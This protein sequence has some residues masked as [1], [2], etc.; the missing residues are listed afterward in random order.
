AA[1]G[2]MAVAGRD[3]GDDHSEDHGLDQG[4]G[5]DVGIEIVLNAGDVVGGA[6]DAGER[7]GEP[8]AE[9]AQEHADDDQERVDQRRG[10]DLRQDKVTGGIHPHDVQRIDLFPNAHGA[11]LRRYRGPHFARQDQGDDGGAELEYGALPY[12]EAH[13]VLGDQGRVNVRFGL[14]GDHRAHEERKQRNDA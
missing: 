6:D 10:D 2:V 4:I 5:D 12:R 9:D 7:A 13:H 14:D 8:S 1:L 3:R 11:D